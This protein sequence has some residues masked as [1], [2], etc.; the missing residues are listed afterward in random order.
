M[1]EELTRSTILALYDPL[2][3]TKVSADASSFGLGAVIIQK[4][5]SGQWRLVAFASRSMTEVECRCVQIEKF[6]DYIL[7]KKI[8]IETDHKLLVSLFNNKCPES[9][10]P[11]VLRFRPRMARVSYSVE[12]VPGK[13]LYTA[14]AL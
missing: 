4:N 3:E 7:G 14:D 9:L 10:P 8:L 13:L 1:K 11:R 6:Q 12:H 5:V 2:L